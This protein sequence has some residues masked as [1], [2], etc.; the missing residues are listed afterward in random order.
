MDDDDEYTI[1]LQDQ[2]VFGAGI[3]RKRI[4][5]VPAAAASSPA[6]DSLYSLRRPASSAAD[7]YLSIVLPKQRMQQDNNNAAESSIEIERSAEAESRQL[8]LEHSQPPSHLDRS[9]VGVKYLTAHGWDPDSGRGLGVRGEG[10]R[11]PIKAREKNDTAGLREREAKKGQE[12]GLI[13]RLNAKQ[14][15][16]KEMAAK[17][18]A[19]ALRAALYNDV[20]VDKYLGSGGSAHSII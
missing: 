20:D 9:R 14:V 18:R 10:I 7:K 11:M 4:A 13:V 15:R 3:K 6:E 19:E 16:K 8:C 17:K 12:D 1:P 2:R 5:F